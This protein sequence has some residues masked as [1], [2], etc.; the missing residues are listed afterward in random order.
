M[1]LCFSQ[2]S[3][4]DQA[5]ILSLYDASLFSGFNKAHFT[6]SKIEIIED[7]YGMFLELSCTKQKRF[8]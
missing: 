1:S 5:N 4:Q 2:R 6:L 3:L 7:Y 8:S